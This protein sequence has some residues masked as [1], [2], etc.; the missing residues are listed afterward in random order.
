MVVFGETTA[1]AVVGE[2]KSF[3]SESQLFLLKGRGVHCIGGGST[4]E[5]VV[6]HE[7]EALT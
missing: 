7:L 1:A 3:L 6:T 2:L 4:G 5:G